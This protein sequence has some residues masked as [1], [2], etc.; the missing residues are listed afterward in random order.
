MTVSGGTRLGPYEILA[1]LGA[2]GMGEVYRA[3]D[4]RLQRE[5]AVK[6]L[7][8]ELSSDAARLKRFEREARSASALNHPNIVTIHEVGQS[9]STSFIVM[10]LVDGKTLRELLYAGPLPLRKLL[11][12]AAQVADGLAKAH[13]SGIVHRDLKAENVMVTSDGFVK[14]LDFGLAKLTHPDSDSGQTEQAPTIPGGTEPGVVMG[15]VG[16]MS[17]EQAAGQRVDFR[18]DQ[19]SFGSILYEMA[20]GKRAFERAT[21]PE[22]LSAIIREEPEPLATVAPKT[23]AHLIWVVERCLAKDPEDRYGSTKD[24]ARD[25]AAMR[26][27]SG[28]QAGLL[29]PVVARR[30]GRELLTTV[31]LAT[32]ALILGVVGTL[33][34]ARARRSDPPRKIQ[35]SL[36]PPEKFAFHNGQM[37]LSPDGRRIAFVA[38]NPGGARVLWVR[39]L[40]SPSAQPLPGTEGACYPFW[41]PDSRFLGFFAGGKLKK[42][43]ASGGAPQTLADAQNGLG[44]SWS[45]EGLILFAPSPQDPIHQVSSSGGAS[46]A[47]TERA[48]SPVEISH[49]WP[50]F[51]PDGRHFLYLARNAQPE[52]SAIYVGSVQ[53]KERKLLVNAESNVAYALPGFLLY[54]RERTLLAQPFDPSGLRLSGEAFPV[55]ERV[56]YF[57]NDASAAFSVSDNGVLVYQAGTAAGESQ[58]AWFDRSGKQLETV[59]APADYTEPRL[60]R[61]GRRVAV[62][63]SDSQGRGD[64]WLY[65]FARRTPTRFTFDPARDFASVWSPDDSRIVFCSV[66]KGPA[67][68]YQKILDGT[69]GVEALL[70]SDAYKIPN[71]W[72]PDG[73]FIAFQM[74]DPT[75]K[76]RLDLW[77]FSVSDRKATLFLQTESNERSARFSPDGRWMAY[78]SDESGKDEVYVQP[79]PGT[80]RRWQVSTAGGRHPTWRGDGRDLV[81]LEP[82]NKL[83]AVEVRTEAAFAAGMPKLLFEPRMKPL[84]QRQFDVSSDGNRFLINLALEEGA[85]APVTLVQNWTAGLK[86]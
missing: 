74:V 41:S 80:G 19:F 29:A 34:V 73:R 47:V 57:V 66:R 7:P 84:V 67:D 30:K 26:K 17:P 33:F 55:G 63:I 42:I 11:S 2:G 59:G 51:L 12:I 49:R 27:D 32:A 71:D 1:Q 56:Q 38:L 48:G 69:G 20:T 60:S 14:I 76:T 16:Y 81:Y 83:M 45:R 35:S 64:L 40:D 72:S 22:T 31:L 78:V 25:L 44:G 15:T 23:P 24:V 39:P 53:S 65:D 8:A 52:K 9:D 50:F 58:L 36:L 79:F 86:P 62:G 75:A 6:V 21:K 37:A 85:S 10:E 82:P 4:T 46:A 68:I 61:D 70:A 77:L 13:A 3:R 18:S 43:D 54:C 28:S 5:V